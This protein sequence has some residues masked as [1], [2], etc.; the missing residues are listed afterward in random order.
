MIISRAGRTD[1]VEPSQ[2]DEPNK[3]RMKRP[4]DAPADTTAV[5][6]A[7]AVL[8]N[9]RAEDFVSDSIGD[10]TPYGLDRP[11]IEVAWETDKLAD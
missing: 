10:G 4:I 1:E 3:W 6:Q 5:T 9:L 2:G 11:A 7:L 8:A